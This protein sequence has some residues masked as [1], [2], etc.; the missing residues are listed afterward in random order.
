M[1]TLRAFYHRS[2]QY[3]S[4]HAESDV[5]ALVKEHDGDIEFDFFF[6]TFLKSQ[7]RHLYRFMDL[8]MALLA[9]LMSH[10][11]QFPAINET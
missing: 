8:F 5:V 2:T 7:S 4:Y 3:Q 9:S 11:V 6:L 10:I 1:L